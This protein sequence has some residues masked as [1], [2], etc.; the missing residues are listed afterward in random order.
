MKGRSCLDPEAGVFAIIGG[1][2]RG[3]GGQSHYSAMRGRLLTVMV[4]DGTLAT[5]VMALAD[6]L[7]IRAATCL[8]DHLLWSRPWVDEEPLEALPLPIVDCRPVRLLPAEDGDVSLAW[9]GS[10][11]SQRSGRLVGDPHV[12][13]DV[14]RGSPYRL[15]DG[16]AWSHGVL[17][18]VL[19]GSATVRRPRDPR[20]RRSLHSAYRIAA[21]HPARARSLRASRGTTDRGWPALGHRRAADLSQRALAAVA[22]AEIITWAATK[23]LHNEDRRAPRAVAARARVTALAGMRSVQLVLRLLPQE[24]DLPQGSSRPSSVWR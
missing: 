11:G 5:E 1:L 24:A 9:A 22:S 21:P 14:E 15:I 2:R 8:A 19:F 18:A 4:G 20:P 16:R 17:H 10:R 3:Y 6:A 23:T 7:P 13:Q 12:P